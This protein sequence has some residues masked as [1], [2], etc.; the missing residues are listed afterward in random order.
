MLNL[1]K[2]R[3]K[4][5]ARFSIVAF[6]YFDFALYSDFEFFGENFHLDGLKYVKYP[7]LV[8]TR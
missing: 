2:T 5:A 6:S 8:I 3:L 7:F 4:S 1:K